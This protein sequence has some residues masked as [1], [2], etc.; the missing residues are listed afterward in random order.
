MLAVHKAR[1]QVHGAGPVQ[2]IEC[3]QIFQPR[4]PRLFQHALH[5]AAFKLKHRLGFAFGKQPV[6]GGVVQR[7]VLEGKML[8]AFVALHDEF[9]RNLQDGERGQAQ[10]VELHQADG[11]HV[12][13]VVLADR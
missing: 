11:L 5:A 10:K 12:V 4:G 7:N 3:N 2:R 9:A 1:N 13:L 6:G 8:L